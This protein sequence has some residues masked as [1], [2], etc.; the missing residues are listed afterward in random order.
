MFLCTL[1]GFYFN[2]INRIVENGGRMARLNT[3]NISQQTQDQYLKILCDFET[4]Q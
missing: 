4:G 3:Q 2:N 1:D